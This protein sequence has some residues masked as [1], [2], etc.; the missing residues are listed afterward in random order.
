MAVEN[1]GG[2]LR[3]R[4]LAYLANH[5]DGS[6]AGRAGRGV[7]PSPHPDSKSTPRADG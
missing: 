6:E 5:P 7:W 3:D 4:L 1:A 2:E